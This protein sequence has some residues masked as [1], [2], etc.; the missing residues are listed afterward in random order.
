[1]THPAQARPSTVISPEHPLGPLRCGPLSHSY[2]YVLIAP[3]APFSFILYAKFIVASQHFRPVL[4]RTC[5][6]RGSPSPMETPRIWPIPPD[7]TITACAPHHCW[8]VFEVR[9]LVSGRLEG[10]SA[11]SINCGNGFFRGR[12]LRD[13]ELS[14]L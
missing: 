14:W 1:M 10:Q 5:P 4:L 2:V 6:L 9:S 7:A 13:G 3:A 8:R 12:C 11:V